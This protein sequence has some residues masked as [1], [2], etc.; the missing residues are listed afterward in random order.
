MKHN[1]PWHGSDAMNTSEQRTA[2]LLAILLCSKSISQLCRLLDKGKRWLEL[3]GPAT[4]VSL[5]SDFTASINEIETYGV[6]YF[7]FIQISRGLMRIPSILQGLV[8]P[9]TGISAQ[10]TLLFV[11][12]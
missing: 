8:H 5:L 10:R 3:R 9:F 7:I 12:T 11:T 2:E 6:I 1:L 4:P